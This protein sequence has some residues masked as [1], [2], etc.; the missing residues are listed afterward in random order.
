MKARIRKCRFHEPLFGPSWAVDIPG[1][2]GLSACG[3]H[4]ETFDG[5]IVWATRQVVELRQEAAAR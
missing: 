5:A 4:F 2:R 1:R 3:F